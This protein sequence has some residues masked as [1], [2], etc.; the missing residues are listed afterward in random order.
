MIS[1][2]YSVNKQTECLTYFTFRNSIKVLNI[3]ICVCV[4][5][6]SAMFKSAILCTVANQVSLSMGFS[7]QEYSSG[8]PFPPLEESSQLWD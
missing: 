3:S 8:F 5:A 6:C 7:R 2:I 4:S 1:K